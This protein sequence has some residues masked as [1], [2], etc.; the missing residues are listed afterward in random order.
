ML[1]LVPY[2]TADSPSRII[3]SYAVSEDYH[4]YF[5]SL[6]ESVIP[7]LEKKYPAASFHGFADSSPIDE[8]G[9]AAM[10]G[11]GVIGRNGLLINEKYGSYVF[12]GEILTDAVLPDQSSEPGYCL[13][14]GA[15]ARACPTGC[16]GDRGAVCLSE[17]TQK[18]GELS[19]SET[20]L[21]RK[22]RTA[23]GCDVCQSVCPMNRAAEPSRIEF[24]C[25]EKIFAPRLGGR[26]DRRA[27]G[28]RKAVTIERNLKIIYG[29]VFMTREILELIIKAVRD[30]GK[31]ML[32]AHDIAGGVAAKEG[33]ANYVTEYDVKVQKLL[34]GSLADIIPDAVFIGEESDSNHTEKLRSGAGFIIDP[35][36]GTTNFINRCKRSAISV[37][38][39]ECGKITAGVVY[40]PY[41]DELFCA[42]RGEGAF[43][44][45]ER[46]A[47]SEN[48]LSRAIVFVGTSPYY[49]ELS[50]YT[51]AVMTAFLNNT[52][53][54]RRSGSAAIDLCSTACGRGDVMF[55]ARLSPWDYAAS[56][57]IIEEAGGVI[58]TMSGDELTFDRP[59]SVLAADKNAYREALELIKPLSD[60]LPEGD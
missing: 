60:R 25:L 45:G 59:C 31:I 50:G 17:L 2:R 49:R 41:L 24:F 6:F 34:Y 29:S 26:I 3:S 8:I 37:G 51:A 57:V 38:V 36:D 5:K 13:D 20:A 54:L 12:I 23:W 19:E 35:I 32:G 56:S 52:A 27:Y 53:D 21:M 40:D 18:K 39:C 55:E 15:C 16:L 10:C 22:Y 9:A 33:K 7:E 44:N 11:L 1:L 48:P 42:M 58:T 14:C 4:L 30:A 28:W 43:L 46:I 47:A